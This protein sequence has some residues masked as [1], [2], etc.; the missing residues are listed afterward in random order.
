MAAEPLRPKTPHFPTDRDPLPGVDNTMRT[1]HS[2]LKKCYLANGESLA[3]IVFDLP[4]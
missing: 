3:Q 4:E 2:I 1:L